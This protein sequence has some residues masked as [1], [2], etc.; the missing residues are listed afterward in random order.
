[1]NL[2]DLAKQLANRINQLHYVKLTLDKVAKNAYNK[3]FKD[4]Q[5]QFK[6]NALLH[7]V[8]GSLCTNFV[9]RDDFSSGICKNCGYKH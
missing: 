5:E 3:G 7:N 8:S 2:E 4:G 9:A 6:N 1:M